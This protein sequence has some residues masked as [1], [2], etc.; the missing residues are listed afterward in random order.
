MSPFDRWRKFRLEIL[1]TSWKIA[2]KD[3]EFLLNNKSYASN[4]LKSGPLSAVCLYNT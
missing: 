1:G 3:L 2:F 4:S